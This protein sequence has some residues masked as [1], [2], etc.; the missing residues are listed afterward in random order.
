MHLRYYIIYCL[1]IVM[2]LLNG[3]FAYD[4]M[5]I[6]ATS[7][8]RGN[9]SLDTDDAFDP[10]LTVARGIM[11]ERA[12]KYIDCYVDLGN[13]FSPGVLSK[14]S[15]GAVMLD[16]FEFVQCDAAL[17]GSRDIAVGLRN[18]ELASR[19]RPTQLL[20]INITVDN[21]PIF[22]PYWIY[23]KNNINIGFI[24]ITS[25]KGIFDVAE[26]QMLSVSLVGYRD[27]LKSTIAALKDNNCKYIII[28]SGLTAAE[29]MML[30]KEY[31]DVSLILAGGDAA[32][33]YYDVYAP[34]VD[35]ED[36]RSIITLSR[37]N[38]Y[39]SVRLGLKETLICEKVIFSDADK[40]VSDSSYYDLIE[41]IN[42]WKERYAE[43]GSAP[44]SENFPATDV[45]S[46]TIAHLLR[47]Y[48]NAEIAIVDVQD[49]FA[50]K[51]AGTVSS[52]DVQRII[53]NDYTIFTYRLNGAQIQ[54]ISNAPTLIFSGLSAGKIQGIAVHPERMYRIVSTQSAYDSIVAILKKEITASNTWTPL[55]AVIT[56]DIKG[57]KCIAN[58]DFAYLDNRVR[59]TVDIN[60]SNIY[61]NSVVKT[62]NAAS[63]PPGMPSK[64]YKKW[65]IEDSADFTLYNQYHRL[66]IT[67][68]IYYMRQDELYLQNLLRGTLFYTYILN[69]Y[70][71]PYHKSQVDTVVVKKDDGLRPVLFRE[72]V[73]ASFVYSYLSGRLG[74]GFEKQTQDPQKEM[75]Y[76]AE[77]IFQIQ[78]PFLDYFLYTF[79]LDNFITV[80]EGS[81][82]NYQIRTEIRNT[83]SIKL[84]TWLALSIRHR[85][86][87]YNPLDTHIPYKYTQL[88]V[89]LDV[90][91]KFKVF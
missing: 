74:F 85:W 19:T 89:S 87:Y 6:L 59:F 77:S 50:T 88:L 2:A 80:P 52:I 86:F 53:Q 40:K 54:A 51:L 48:Y 23:K 11:A 36:G 33:L 70:I 32:G 14:Y 1:C 82:S 3:A 68:Y 65:G 4:T 84:N 76:G 61:D 79:N 10:L 55:S 62:E 83:L 49:V 73:G 56:K 38:G 30:M 22:K 12:T 69:P 35:L 66:T 29:N 8:L 60:L 44:L 58:K 26:K 20:S 90:K 21:K 41:R 31:P 27:Y 28:L 67:P 13:A 46:V 45:S 47:H 75:L 91:A 64:T 63:R 9:F 71:N 81:N 72:T 17:I 5:T 37:S 39:Y 57:H 15:Y 16:F 18:L 7:N 24:G 78:I 42:L 25:S 43:V 34:R